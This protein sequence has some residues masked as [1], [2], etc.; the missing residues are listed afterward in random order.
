M[1]HFLKVPAM[2]TLSEC[3]AVLCILVG[4]CYIVY[5]NVLKS[6]NKAIIQQSTSD[7]V[8][9]IRRTRLT[10]ISKSCTAQSTFLPQAGVKLY[11]NLP[12]FFANGKCT[13]GDITLQY[14]EQSANIC[15]QQWTGKIEVKY[16]KIPNSDNGVPDAVE[17]VGD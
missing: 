3:V 10:A 14:K 16:A 1:S 6:S 5:P 7:L 11:G 13:G 17:C 2:T 9:T 4:M 8:Q 12:T 15:V